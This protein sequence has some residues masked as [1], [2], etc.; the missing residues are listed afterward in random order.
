MKRNV[1]L[2]ESY[3]RLIVGFTT[4]GYGIIKKSKFSVLMGSIGIA[5]G[6]TRWCPMKALFDSQSKGNDI[7]NIDLKY[8]YNIEDKNP[9]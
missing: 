5:E 4:F 9:T 2:L 7:S 1:G 3:L 6:L 8:S